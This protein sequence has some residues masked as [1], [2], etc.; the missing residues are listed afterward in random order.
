MGGMSFEP[1]RT[2]AI[3]FLADTAEEEPE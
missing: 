1:I 3:G 2:H